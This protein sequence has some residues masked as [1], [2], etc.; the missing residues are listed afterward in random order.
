LNSLAGRSHA[1]DRV[2]VML[3]TNSLLKTGLIVGLLWY[4]WFSTRH[5]PETRRRVVMTIVAA[6]IAIF[7][8]RTGQRIL[9]PRLRPIHDPSLALRVAWDFNPSS[10]AEWSSFPSDHAVLLCSLAAGLWTISR[11]WGALAFIW[12]LGFVFPV[13]LILGLHYPSDI[14]AGGLV[15]VAIVWLVSLDRRVVPWIVDQA[16]K[17]E[18]RQAAVFYTSV[19][20]LTWQVADFFGDCRYMVHALGAIALGR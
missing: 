5:Q 14:L 10:H 4:A 12:V 2:V 20:L 11:A 19:F 8:A 17:L 15:G 1:F 13:R 18:A 7:V 6:C 3:E 9:P 16:M